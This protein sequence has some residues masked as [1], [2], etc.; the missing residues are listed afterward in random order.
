MGAWR[1]AAREGSG[2][3]L[4]GAA[5]D[6]GARG[7]GAVTAA[8]GAARGGC[9]GPAGEAAAARACAPGASGTPS[10]G[11]AGG[12]RRGALPGAPAARPRPARIAGGSEVRAAP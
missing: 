4:C 11:L 10:L 8:G 9:I 5:G 1:G 2:A 3:A 7:R 6:C 12:V